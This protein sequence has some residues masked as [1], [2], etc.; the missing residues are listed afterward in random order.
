MTHFLLETLYDLLTAAFP[1][2]IDEYPSIL[3]L[4]SILNPISSGNPFFQVGY[5]TMWRTELKKFASIV[6]KHLNKEEVKVVE[7][8][9]R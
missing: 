1:V 6:P 5:G 8:P 4:L 9:K 7:K 2:Q 3:K